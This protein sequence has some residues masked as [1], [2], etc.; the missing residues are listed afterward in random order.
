MLHDVQLLGLLKIQFSPI[1]IS[2][3]CCESFGD[4]PNIY[5]P[6]F[7]RSIYSTSSE[8]AAPADWAMVHQKE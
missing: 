8:S 5:Q 2:S 1:S 7:Y 3:Q 4:A 6:S